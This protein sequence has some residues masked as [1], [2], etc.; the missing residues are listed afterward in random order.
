MCGYSDSADPAADTSVT[1][2]ND[3]CQSKEDA[4]AEAVAND[5]CDAYVTLDADSDDEL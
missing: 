5:D 1:T 2:T 3:D 4:A